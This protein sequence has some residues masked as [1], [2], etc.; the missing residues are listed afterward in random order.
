M[1]TSGILC[2]RRGQE[3]G[4][5]AGRSGSG[6]RI[7][8]PGNEHDTAAEELAGPGELGGEMPGVADGGILIGAVLSNPIGTDT[9]LVGNVKEEAHAPD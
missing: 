6:G 7:R 8:L 9:V 4:R 2:R 3:I 5:R 1:R